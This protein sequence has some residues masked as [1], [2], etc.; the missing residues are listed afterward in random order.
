MKY[1]QNKEKSLLQYLDLINSKFNSIKEKFKVLFTNVIYLILCWIYK[2]TVHI[3]SVIKMISNPN[4]LI[5][6]KT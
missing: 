1:K 4:Y 5:L 3:K 2:T 6:Y